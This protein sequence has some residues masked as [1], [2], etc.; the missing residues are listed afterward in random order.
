ML[1]KSGDKFCCYCG[2]TKGGRFCQVC[3]T[4]LLRTCP[5]C[6]E[7]VP[8]GANYCY[9]CRDGK[10]P[11]HSHKKDLVKIF[12]G[13][14]INHTLLKIKSEL[15][16]ING[17]SF[18]E[19]YCP[20][21]GQMQLSFEDTFRCSLCWGLY[22]CQRHKVGEDFL[23][24]LCASS[25]KD[26]H[27]AWGKRKNY[28]FTHH[29]SGA[30]G[31][32]A[33]GTFQKDIVL[34]PAGEF[35]MGDERQSVGLDSFYIDRYPVT[36]AQFRLFDPGYTYPAG[37]DNYPATTRLTWYRANAYARWVGKRLP[38]EEEW[39]KAARGTDGRLYPWGNQFDPSRCNTKESGILGF[40]PVDQYPTGQSPYGCFD[41]AGNVLEWTASWFDEQR[42]FMVVKGG[43]WDDFDYVARCASHMGYEHFYPMTMIIGFRC[44]KDA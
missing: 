26:A 14:R 13:F 1:G 37:R 21:C 23:C 12:K 15:E 30:I 4:P 6:Q 27:E 16:L 8:V 42:N 22:I 39:E 5:Q 9:F 2:E 36:N 29:P 17:R 41:M 19:I 20:I 31:N 11:D 33:I 32:K 44:V 34:V 7:W 18:P 24:E 40:T 10:H 38:S 3:G 28:D 35:L 25:P 43:S